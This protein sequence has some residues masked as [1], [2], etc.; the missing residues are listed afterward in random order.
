MPLGVPASSQL[1]LA[2]VLPVRQPHA[3]LCRQ[4]DLE[5]RLKPMRGLKRFLVPSSG[6]GPWQPVLFQS[7][8]SQIRLC[9]G[10]MVGANYRI[11][12]IDFEKD[13]LSDSYLVR[14]FHPPRPPPKRWPNSHIMCCRERR[15]LGRGARLLLF[16]VRAP[17]APARM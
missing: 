11:P 1:R 9:Y 4:R 16:L 15:M 14:Y 3:P 2:G 13:C 6:V 5:E 12:K 8:A 10:I 17:H 7:L